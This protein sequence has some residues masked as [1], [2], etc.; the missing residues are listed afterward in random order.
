MQMCFDGQCSRRLSWP[1]QPNYTFAEFNYRSSEKR[2]FS[3]ASVLKIAVNPSTH[4]P[5]SQPGSQHWRHLQELIFEWRQRVAA[6][7][8]EPERTTPV[9]QIRSDRFINGMS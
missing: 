4:S 6:L 5:A 3:P 8:P 7:I 1:E 2:N 9:P